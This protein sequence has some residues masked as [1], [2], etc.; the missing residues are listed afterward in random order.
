MTETFG[1]VVLPVSVGAMTTAVA[2]YALCFSR[3]SAFRQFGA[4]AGT[5]ILTTLAASVTVLPALLA[6]FPKR[7]SVGKRRAAA[8]IAP[9]SRTVR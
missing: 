4:I 5:G 3:T 9:R 2:F 1:A 8:S 7:R 6:A